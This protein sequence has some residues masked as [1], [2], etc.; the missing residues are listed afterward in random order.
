MTDD[1]K[2]WSRE[3][4]ESAYV[5]REVQLKKATE[6]IEEA[7]LLMAE[8]IAENTELKARVAKLEFIAKWGRGVGGQPPCDH[9]QYNRTKHGRYCPCG[10]QMWD[11]GD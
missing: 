2:S 9:K 4:L 8:A 7:R 11:A 3:E 1:I 5:Q 6:G 10:V